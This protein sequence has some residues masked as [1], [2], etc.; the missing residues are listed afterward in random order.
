M[1]TKP[2]GVFNTRMTRWRWRIGSLAVEASS[3]TT[4]IG[5]LKDVRVLDASGVFT[6]QR[7]FLFEGR[8]EFVVS[9]MRLVVA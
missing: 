8:N 4:Q 1:E 9:L 2:T 5:R 7:V 3:G 6:F